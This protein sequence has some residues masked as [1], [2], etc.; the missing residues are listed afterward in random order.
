MIRFECDYAEGAHP[1]VLEA[2]VKTNFEQ[3]PG[4]GADSHCAHAQELIREACEDPLANVYFVTGGTP[5]NV[6]VI[7]SLLRPY[8]GCVC[9]K[10]GHINVHEAGAV[11]ATGHKVI[12]L[13]GKDGKLS[14]ETLRNYL[15]S[16]WADPTHE[17]MVQPGMVYISHPT[18]YGSLYTLSEVEAIRA[19]C[20]T[21]GLPLY[22]DGARLGYALA[23]KENEL[24]LQDLAR[25]SDAFYIG[26]TKVGALLGEAIVFPKGMDKLFPTHAKRQGAM[27]AKGFVPAI[28]FSELFTDHLYERLGRHGI[29]MAMEL[30]KGLLEKG[31]ALH[32]DSYTNQQFVILPEKVVQA[33]RENVDF[34]VWERKDEDTLVVRFVTSWST[35]KEDVE[36]LLSLL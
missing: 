11:E 28:Q 20:N 7:A 1:K 36:K 14:A 33:L 30:K 18:E 10:S 3:S 6:T 35:K 12:G 24:T 4:Y 13:E 2:L 23:A 17:H 9:C 21:Y 25:L 22:I 31:Y 32:I 27:L 8:Q 15:E 34:E 26:G 5:A 16:Y 19:V 29:D